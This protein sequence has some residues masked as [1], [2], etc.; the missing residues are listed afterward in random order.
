[1]KTQTALYREIASLVQARLNCSRSGN[2]EWYDKHADSIEKLVK[3]H[4]PSGSGID[5]GTAIDLDEST[6][7]KLVFTFGYHHMDENG[8]Y[9]GWTHHKLVVRPSLVHDIDMKISGENRND[10]KEYLYDTFHY[11]LTQEN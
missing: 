6:P 9:D 8:Y 11:A 3:D 7:N 1:M 4:M 10:I 5:N 2:Q